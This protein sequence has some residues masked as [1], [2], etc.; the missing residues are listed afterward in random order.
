MRNLSAT[1]YQGKDL[2]IFNMGFDPQL[3]ESI[4]SITLF[5]K[6]FPNACRVITDESSDVIGCFVMFPAPRYYIHHNLLD[7]LPYPLG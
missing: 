2:S 3:H 7:Q 4:E 5:C 6:K 1:E